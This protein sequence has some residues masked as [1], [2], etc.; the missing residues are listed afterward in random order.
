MEVKLTESTQDSLI[1]KILDSYRVR[2]IVLLAIDVSII[3]FGFLLSSN[4]TGITEPIYCF[5]F[6]FI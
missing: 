6:L 2:Q 1:V 4:L 3:L 5:L